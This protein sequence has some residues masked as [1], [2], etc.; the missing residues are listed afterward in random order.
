MTS[1]LK[2]WR[3]EENENFEV[4]KSKEILKR[5]FSN[6]AISNSSDEWRWNEKIS[7]WT[8]FIFFVLQNQVLKKLQ[9]LYKNRL[10]IYE[11]KFSFDFQLLQFVSKDRKS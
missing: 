3:E 2:Y 6:L 5:T 1:S 11:F 7:Y 4:R 9:S 8:A 10:R